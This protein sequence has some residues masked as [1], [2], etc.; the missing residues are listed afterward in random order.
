MLPMGQF[1]ERGIFFEN[2]FAT[3]YWL[4]RPE[5]LIDVDPALSDVAVLAEPF[6]VAEKA[7]NEVMILQTARL[8]GLIDVYRP[9]VLVTGMGPIAFAA[10]LI[11]KCLG[12]PTTIAG[13]DETDSF[14]AQ[15]VGEF[16]VDYRKIVD[17]DFGQDDVEDV[18]Y[19]L[20]LECTG[21]DQV[22]VE[23]GSWIRSCGAIVWLGASRIPKSR[24]LSVDRMMGEAIF[25]NHIILGTV[26]S[27]HRDFVDAL[28]HLKQLKA[29]YPSATNKL[30]TERL[31]AKDSLE[32]YNERTKQSVKTLVHF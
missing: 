10:A 19:D 1:T 30:F 17:M 32:F 21:N 18:G 9:R 15:L 13:R 14:R 5:F 2:G 4:D 31:S 24:T 22:A 26:N 16:D 27:A 6:A 20:L 29:E 25:R 23:F 7:V 12:W 3:K 28:T 11:S 8:E